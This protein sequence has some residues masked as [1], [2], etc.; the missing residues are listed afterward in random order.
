MH[1]SNVR[2]QLFLVPTGKINGFSQHRSKL[3]HFI[4]FLQAMKSAINLSPA[5]CQRIHFVEQEYI[6]LVR[7]YIFGVSQE[8]RYFV[9]V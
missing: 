3:C 2:L 7:I 8:K 5:A 9:A 4:D 6:Y 1:Y